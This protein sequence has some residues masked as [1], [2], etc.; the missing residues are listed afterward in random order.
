MSG[1]NS[2]VCKLSPIGC[3]SEGEMSEL[4]WAKRINKRRTVVQLSQSDN[5]KAWNRVWFLLIVSIVSKTKDENSP[6]LS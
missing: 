5:M 1:I 6:V 3:L 4:L 2:S